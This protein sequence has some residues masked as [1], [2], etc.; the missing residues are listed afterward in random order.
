MTCARLPE[1]GDETLWTLVPLSVPTAVHS[2]PIATREPLL[3][4][5]CHLPG[6]S[7]WSQVLRLGSVWTLS[8]GFLRC[9]AKPPQTQ[10]FKT[11]ERYALI[12]LVARGPNTTV[13]EP[14]PQETS[15]PSLGFLQLYAF[16]GFRC[17]NPASSSSSW[18]LLSTV[19]IW[20][21]P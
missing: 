1:D 4:R 12:V 21:P 16:S 14:P 6:V 15:L 20:S 13:S 2:G 18:D 3:L 9:H 8:I 17:K 10:G 19:K 7:S 5:S 11:T